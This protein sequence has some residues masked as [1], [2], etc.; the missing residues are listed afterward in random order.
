MLPEISYGLLES[1]M[2]DAS[3]FSLLHTFCSCCAE[4]L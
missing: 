4:W 2:T 1:T 3:K